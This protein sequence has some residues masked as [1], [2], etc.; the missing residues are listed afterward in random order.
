MNRQE[1]VTEATE[2]IGPIEVEEALL[3]NEH[4]LQEEAE[5]CVQEIQPTRRSARGRIPRKRPFGDA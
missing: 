3:H 1:E 2:T 5:Q 4:S